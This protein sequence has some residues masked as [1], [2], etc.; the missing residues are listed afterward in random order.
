MLDKYSTTER[1]GKL[2]LRSQPVR[3][4]PKEFNRLVKLHGALVEVFIKAEK[5]RSRERIE[6]DRCRCNS[7]NGKERMLEDHD[8]WFYLELK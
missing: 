8:C 7:M 4:L 6:A 5:G 3:T 1:T 2:Q